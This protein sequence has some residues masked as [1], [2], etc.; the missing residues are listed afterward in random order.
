M[1]SYM[2]RHHWCWEGRGRRHK[3]HPPLSLLVTSGR[4]SA[5]CVKCILQTNLCVCNLDKTI[6]IDV[7]FSITFVLSSANVLFSQWSLWLSFDINLPYLNYI[8]WGYARNKTTICVYI[9]RWT[10]KVHLLTFLNISKLIAVVFFGLVDTCVVSK[11]CLKKL[12]YINFK[13]CIS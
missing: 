6:S 7:S 11:L 8:W 13:N 3:A 10:L 1:I 12:T 5:S 4:A 9:S 2:L